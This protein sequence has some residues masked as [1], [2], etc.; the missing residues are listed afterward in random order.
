MP[1]VQ[2]INS[3]ARESTASLKD[4]TEQV[5]KEV[6]S[7]FEKTQVFT[8]PALEQQ[9][10]ETSPEREPE[11]K[12]QSENEQEPVRTAESPKLA[13]E[14]SLKSQEDS[15]SSGEDSEEDEELSSL[16]SDASDDSYTR[17]E[18]NEMIRDLRGKFTQVKRTIEGV[19][20]KQMQNVL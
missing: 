15:H 4:E 11:L 14:E 13:P 12:E 8:P 10:Q 2:F 19:Q 5:I 6:E 9:A 1:L 16:E 20:T 17:Q 18:L 3:A 7:E